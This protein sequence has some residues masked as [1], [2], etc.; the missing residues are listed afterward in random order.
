MEANSLCLT[1]KFIRR[2]PLRYSPAGIPILEFRLLHVSNQAEAGMAL[3]VEFEIGGKAVSDIAIKLSELQTGNQVRLDGF[4]SPRNRKS[5]EI[6]FHA[7]HFEL[8]G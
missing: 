8:I 7:N 3:K 4:L 2:E 1:G 6:V 5:S